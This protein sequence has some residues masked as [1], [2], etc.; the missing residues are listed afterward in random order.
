MHDLSIPYRKGKWQTK[1]AIVALLKDQVV[2]RAFRTVLLLWAWNGNARLV[3]RLFFCVVLSLGYLRILHA[4]C[5]WRF[6]KLCDNSV[7]RKHF[8]NLFCIAGN[9]RPHLLRV[10]QAL[11]VV[12]SIEL[13]KLDQSAI[14]SLD[15]NFEELQR[16][17]VP[18]GKGY[19]VSL[20]SLASVA[21]KVII[22]WA[23]K[24]GPST[25]RL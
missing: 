20:V 19:S 6:L 11:L 1:A 10:A 25:F 2:C 12:S 5:L 14:H 17:A 23:K 18:K 8:G 22:I 9:N 4:A 15:G 7:D 3:G 24:P 16:A 13:F 21:G